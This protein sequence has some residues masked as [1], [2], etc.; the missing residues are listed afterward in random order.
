MSEQ[1]CSSVAVSL[2][3][4]E[5]DCFGHIVGLNKCMG[6][7]DVRCAIGSTEHDVCLWRGVRQK[8]VVT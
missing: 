6:I 5:P 4:G 8:E 1:L 3:V 7:E 2:G